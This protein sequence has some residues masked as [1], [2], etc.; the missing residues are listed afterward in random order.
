[1]FCLSSVRISKSFLKLTISKYIFFYEWMEQTDLTQEI[2][3]LFKINPPDF[4]YCVNC[5]K[6]VVYLYIDQYRQLKKNG[7]PIPL[8]VRKDRLKKLSTIQKDRLIDFNI[9]IN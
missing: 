3:Q 7:Q 2:K 5:Q 8:F 4:L 6:S 9:Q 1:M